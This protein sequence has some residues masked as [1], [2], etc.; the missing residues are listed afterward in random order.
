MCTHIRLLQTCWPEQNAWRSYAL[1]AGRRRLT[2]RC[3]RYSPL[4]PPERELRTRSAARR[5]YCTFLMMC[6]APAVVK[7]RPPCALRHSPECARSPLCLRS[8]VLEASSITTELVMLTLTSTRSPPPPSPVR[9][10]K[11]VSK[12][13]TVYQSGV[14]CRYGFLSDTT[15]CQALAYSSGVWRTCLHSLGPPVCIPMRGVNV[16]PQE[17]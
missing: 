15:R 7:M 3:C 5:A 1:R 10:S 9:R 17:V 13:N 8:Q 12:F 11:H 2:C 16:V 4:S 14:Q 6:E